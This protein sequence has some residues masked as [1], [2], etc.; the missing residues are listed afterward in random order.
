MNTHRNRY[1]KV[2]ALLAF[3]LGAV[4]LT[5]CASDKA[6]EPVEMKVPAVW[7]YVTGADFA[8]LDVVDQPGVDTL[9]VKRVLAPTEAWI[10]VHLDD[11]GM[12]GDRVGF[13]RI[14]KGQ[15]RD[16]RVPLSGVTSEKVIVA[17]HADKGMPG[18]FEFDM[19]NKMQSPDRPFFVNDKELAMAVVVKG[20]ETGAEDSQGAMDA[21]GQSDTASETPASDTTMSET[22]AQTTTTDD[23]SMDQPTTDDAAMSSDS[24]KDSAMSDDSSTKGESSDEEGMTESETPSS[25]AWGLLGGFLVLNA[26]IIAYA[27]GRKR[28]SAKAKSEGG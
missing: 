20:D 26:L 6:K 3:A 28:G 24:S 5:G 9:V 12:P 23:A 1:L 16:V 17:V 8:Q 4:A 2:A 14:P 15:S 11:N 25:P 18:E 10:V 13:T 27:A 19:M 22:P 21:T 7:G